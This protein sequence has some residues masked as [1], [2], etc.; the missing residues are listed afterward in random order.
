MRSR[1]YLYSRYFLPNHVLRQMALFTTQFLKRE[2]C[3]FI[4]CITFLYAVYS[5]CFSI[6]FN[7]ESSQFYLKTLR[8]KGT[9]NGK[10]SET[11]CVLDTDDECVIRSQLPFSK[12]LSNK[13]YIIIIIK[14][15]SVQCSEIGICE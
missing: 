4:S 13:H 2:P 7:L 3:V 5:L 14:V 15:V 11:P 8:R 1:I 9:G 10:Q 6:S 12:L